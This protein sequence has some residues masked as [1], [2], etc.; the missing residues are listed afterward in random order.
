L[1]GIAGIAGCLEEEERVA[2]LEEMSHVQAHRGP[3]DS[4][5]WFGKRIA[6]AHRR[7]A[8]IDPESNVQPMSYAGGRFQITYNGELYNSPDLR[9]ALDAKGHSFRTHSDT[10][11]I[12]AAYAE[13][14]IDCLEKFNGIFAFGLW[15]E[16]TK[17]LLLAR[18]PL[19]VKP[20]YWSGDENGIV[21]ASELR[22]VLAGSG[23]ERCLNL[24]ALGEWLT[25]RYVPSPKTLIENVWKLPPAGTLLWQDGKI[26]RGCYRQEPPQVNRLRSTSEWI[27][28]YEAELEAAVRRQLL[29]DVPVGLFLSGGVDSGVLLAIMSKYAA[30]PVQTF[31]VG[32][33]EAGSF[34]ELA[35]ARETARIFGAE[36]H[37]TVISTT[38]YWDSLGSVIRH[39]EE[40]VATPSALAMYFMS[41]HAGS[42]LKVVLTGQGADEPLAGY[43]RYAGEKWHR[44]LACLGRWP[45]RPLVNALPRNE[46]LKRAAAALGEHDTARRFKKAYALFDE[47]LLRDLIRPE[48]LSE[49]TLGIEEPLRRLLGKVCHLESVAQMMYVDTRMWLPD[50]LL[51]YGDKMSMAHSLEARVPYLDLDLLNLVESMP[52][53]MRLHG[54]ATGKYVHK[55]AARKWL[56]EEILARKKKGFDT[57]MDRWLRRIDL[58]ERIRDSL[59][60]TGSACR[61]YF[62]PE[63]ILH[64]LEEHRR[65]SE[66]RRRQIFALLS[67]EEWHRQI[68]WESSSNSGKSIRK[69][70]GTRTHF[71]GHP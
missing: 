39:L 70:P 55:Q 28:A 17:R 14:G 18:D 9:R 11:V 3:D 47:V 22:A 29:S 41:E 12:L 32:F 31:T 7:L 58:S 8:I 24:H 21:F 19:G 43:H 1:C 25:Y 6:L 57:P 15:D 60:G 20:L 52:A 48:I 36:H 2:R 51:L 35:D 4:G 33:E 67:L 50:D 34:N 64:L 65:G 10:E 71:N 13:W 45:L 46:R 49:A 56:P 16:N 63:T 66:D 37:E 27:A 40:P 42:R 26:E 44:P 61:E 62:R 54:I 5:T 53:G 30:K 38:K 23:I 59:L 68:L 69:A